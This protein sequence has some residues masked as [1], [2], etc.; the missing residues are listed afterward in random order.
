MVMFGRGKSKKREKG[1]ASNKLI[2]IKPT[3]N[4]FQ[5]DWEELWEARDLLYFLTWRDIK[6]RYKQTV[7]GVLWILIQPLI[8]IVIFTIIFGNFAKIPSD[9]IPYPIF[10]FI[11]LLFWNFF[12][13]TLSS[14]S[15]SL[16]SNE[17]ILKKIYFPRLLAP[18]SSI[19]AHLVD[20]IPTFIILIGMMIY[21]KVGVT[22]Q[23]IILIPVLLLMIL[24][25]S[26]GAGLFLSP[27]NAKFRD[28]RYILPFFIQLMMF[29]TPV[30]YSTSMFGGTSK[31]VRMFNP[32][33]EAIDV[34]RSGFFN[35]RPMDWPTFFFSIGLVVVIFLIG[36]IFF[37]SQEDSFV[38]IL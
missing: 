9:N 11:G 17:N 26:M 37:K 3:K 24:F 18:I 12:S 29:A 22:L 8:S 35:T 27:I 4:L 10:V 32:V 1:K 30:L 28:I 7:L 15:N 38:D 14:A 20:L 34:S 6:I 31:V 19:L 33:A 5:I 36:L 16:I 2:V 21:Y 23:M 25:C 13:S